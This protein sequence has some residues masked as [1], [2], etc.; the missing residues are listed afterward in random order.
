MSVPADTSKPQSDPKTPYKPPT[1][2]NTLIPGKALD[3]CLEQYKAYLADLGNVG[4]RYATL[5]GF[6]VSVIAALLTLLALADTNKLFFKIET[7]ELIVV[8]VFSIV[9]CII[10][11]LTIHFYGRLFRAKFTILKAL[12][13]HLAYPCFDAEYN[14]LVPK[15][16]L[17][18]IEAW[19]PI[20]LTL[21]FAAMAAIRLIGH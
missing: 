6:Y 19:I 7:N 3:V 11:S 10:W 1:S 5:Q 16:F 9:L 17:T 15:H 14:L 20:A 13:C 8:C 21:F 2:L 18:K 12:E 4:T